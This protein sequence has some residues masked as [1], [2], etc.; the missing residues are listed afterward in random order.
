MSFSAGCHCFRSTEGGWNLPAWL[1]RTHFSSF[2]GQRTDHRVAIAYDTTTNTPASDFVPGLA[3]NYYGTWALHVDA[4]GCLYVGG[5]YTRTEAGGWIGGFGRFCEPTPSPAGLIASTGNQTVRLDW[6]PP[7]SQLPI[8][9]YKVYRDG[10]FLG[11]TPGLTYTIGSLAAGTTPAFTVET[12]DSS[13]RRS[14]PAAVTVTVAGPDVTPPSP[15][16]AVSGSVAGSDVRVTWDAAVDDQG[17]REY[18]VHRDYQFVAVLPPNQLQYV[19]PGVANGPHRYDIR[20]R[21]LAGLLS[22]PAS[23]T[24]TVGA[25][26]VLAPTIPQGVGGVAN[27]S[28]V[29]V[30]WQ[31][32]TDQPNPGG[33]GV[34]GYLIHDNYQ[35]LAWVPAGTSYSHLGA[36]NG[37]HRYHVRAQDA[38]GNN[39]GP[40]SLVSVWVGPTD[41]EAPQSPS[42]VTYTTAGSSVTLA[43]SAAADLPNPGG[44]GVTGYLVH[45]DWQFVAWVPAGTVYADTNVPAGQHRYEIR[46]QDGAGNNS[47]PSTPLIVSVN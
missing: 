11:D 30:G 7:V 35:F 8:V 34:T 31:A 22:D 43:W 40:S 21:D 29:S 27:G 39:S 46:A 5:Y 20:A 3:A 9:K 47:I 32:S 33:S 16:G 28:T 13:G 10:V 17:I 4:N 23:T 24:V 15:P 45:R 38:A 6:T 1:G 42:N 18:L 14:L 25:P 41:G 44:S 36:A 37:Y 12:V 19:D 26:D 2:T